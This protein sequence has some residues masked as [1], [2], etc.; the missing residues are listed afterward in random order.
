MYKY[1]T[2]A[3]NT[4]STCYKSKFLEIRKSY[5]QLKY[6]PDYFFKNNASLK[7]ALSSINGSFTLSY[8]TKKLLMH[9][10]SRMSVVRKLLSEI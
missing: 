5:K 10:T 8:S 4:K 9:Y 3:H 1:R 2:L 6:L 7:T